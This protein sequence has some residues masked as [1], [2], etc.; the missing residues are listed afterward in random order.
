MLLTLGD[1]SVFVFTK[2][3]NKK[4]FFPTQKESCLEG[5]MSSFT[6]FHSFSVSEVYLFCKDIRFGSWR[7]PNI[8]LKTECLDLLTLTNMVIVQ[9]EYT[10]Y[11]RFLF[12]YIH[13]Y[14]CIYIRSINHLLPTHLT[15]LLHTG[16]MRARPPTR[17]DSSLFIVY[18]V[19]C[20]HKNVTVISA[21]VRM[22]SASSFFY[23]L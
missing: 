19:I 2:I 13:M 6:V 1:Y 22:C 4:N 3:R 15:Q 10:D 21:R 8:K 20:D 14:I 7:E 9:S 5:K 23:I 18:K 11:V 16:Q 12:A 17:K